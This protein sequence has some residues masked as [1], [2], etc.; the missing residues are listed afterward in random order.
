MHYWLFQ[1]NKKTFNILN[2][3]YNYTILINN[4]RQHMK[5]KKKKNF[6]YSG[7]ME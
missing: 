3:K 1:Y 7:N 2:L 6:K 4:R 5:K